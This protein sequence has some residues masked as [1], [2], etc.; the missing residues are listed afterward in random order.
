M[1]QAI[2]LINGILIANLARTITKGSKLNRIVKNQLLTLSASLT[3]WL[4]ATYTRTY[5]AAP[6]HQPSMKYIG[7]ISALIGIYALFKLSSRFPNKIQTKE[8]ENK[9]AA[10]TFHT[11]TI[12]KSTELVINKFQ[13]IDATSL[14]QTIYNIT[15]ILI[16]FLGVKR[17]TKKTKANKEKTHKAT[18]G[19]IIFITT[20]ITF[21]IIAPNQDFDTTT[22]LLITLAIFLFSTFLSIQKEKL[23]LVNET[24][25]HKLKNS[26]A[27][28]ILYSTTLIC[29]TTIN[30]SNKLVNTLVITTMGYLAT[31]YFLKKFPT[32][33]DLKEKKLKRIININNKKL[34]KQF[35][36]IKKTLRQ[37]EEFICATAHEFKTPITS[38][39]I[40]LEG[41]K[42][43]RTTKEIELLEE[44]LNQIALM[45]NNFF[46]AKK[47]SIQETSKKLEP[48]TVKNLVNKISKN[49]QNSSIITKLE[50]KTLHTKHKIKL[51]C[52]ISSLLQVIQNLIS[53]AIKANATQIEILIAK[54]K[55]NLT[56]KVTNNGTRI[57]QTERKKIF[58]PFHSNDR[59]TGMGMGLYICK[60]I[61]K[62]HKGNIKLHTDSNTSFIITLPLLPQKFHP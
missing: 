59:K 34:N 8:V 15:F 27:L 12:I 47:R 40:N 11:T 31:I 55:T 58:L 36:K 45:A 13:P 19:L 23:G 37:Q 25:K 32:P 1:N 35:R 18:T 61:I 56:I 42:K 30:H 39:I 5:I 48:T 2:Y 53:N 28:L 41:I 21:R 26:T 17:L 10:M 9:I 16:S 6:L 22:A 43:E 38:A 57:P 3:V 24:Y 62:K 54:R 60:E 44:S 20:A 33:Q 14:T 49:I 7:D 51:K 52:N 50:N 46:K 4:T 29:S